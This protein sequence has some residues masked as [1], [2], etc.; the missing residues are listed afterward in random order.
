M[1]INCMDILYNLPIGVYLTDNKRQI[2]YWN[3]SAEEITGYAAKDV[4][5]SCCYDNILV[6]VDE[7][8]NSL[9][10]SQCPL[11]KTI[12][13]GLI[14]ESNVFLNHKDGHRVAVKVYTIPLQDNNKETIGGAEVFSDISVMTAMQLKTKELEKMAFFD[15][16]TKLPNREHI[17]AEIMSMFHEYNRYSIPFGILFLDID[18][19]KE[20][21]DTYGHDSGDQVLRT[22]AATLRSSSRL[23]D[24]FGRWGGEELIGIIR[25]VDSN[26]LSAVGNRYRALIEKSHVT[27][28]KKPVG[29]TVS[30]G[31]TVVRPEDT[32]DSI[33]SRAD[34][35]M[36]MS[37]QKGRNCL[38]TD[39]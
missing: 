24:M 13:D 19:F 27:I 18:H 37:K 11:A 3:K 36:Y 29:I 35:L 28:K 8:G 31:A 14:R 1:D 2:V 6:H 38:T 15:A 5:G 17:Q 7:W 16:L 10:K 26:A 9:C 4:I 30:I 12:S 21:N 23:F 39:I 25:H 22:V 20:F 33:I 34:H 32:I